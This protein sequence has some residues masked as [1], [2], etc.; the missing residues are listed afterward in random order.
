MFPSVIVSRLL[1]SL[2]LVFVTAGHAA[3]QDRRQNAP[4]EFDFYVLALSWSP[5]FCEAASERGNS[6]RSAQIQCERPFSFVVHGLWPQY[7]RGF[8]EYC[9]RPSPRLDRNIMTSMLDLMP[10]P[11]LIFNEWDKHGTCSGLGARAYFENI[12]KARAAVKI[13][14]EF[15]QLSESKTI[16]PEALE[17]A[18]IKVNPGLSSSAISVVCSSRRLSEV[19][20]C[21][22]KDLQFRSCEE[23]DRRACRRDEVVMPPV[24]GS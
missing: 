9:Q 21:M 3:A 23:I 17:A 16:A 18:F 6:G 20:V 12:R 14:E 5:S 4:G 7:E 2:A 8:P 19:R 22:S 10:A 15:L 13:P 11:G 24:R 1:I